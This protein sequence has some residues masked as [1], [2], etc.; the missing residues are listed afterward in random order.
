MNG[1]ATCFV[2]TAATTAYDTSEAARE[3]AEQLRGHAPRLVLFFAGST[4][5]LGALAAE[6]APRLPGVRVAGCSTM[7]EIGPLGLTQGGVSALGIGAPARVSATLVDLELLHFGDGLATV[8]RLAAELGLSPS[9]L[10]PDEHVFVT[11]TDGLSGLE[12]LLIASL[13]THAPRI[14]LVGGSAG[15][16]FR[17]ERTWVALDG[18][19]RSRAALVLLLEP[20][21]PFR[22]FHLHHFWPSE[23]RVVVTSAEPGRRLV[24]ELDGKPAVAVLSSLLGI[25]EDELRGDPSAIARQHTVFA[26]GVADRFYIRSVMTVTDDALLMGGAVGEGAVLRVM[27]GGDL[28]GATRDGV[29]RAVADIPS[30]G[31]GLLLF[32]C[33][34]RLLEA[35]AAGAERALYEAMT[36]IP[37]AG[38]TTYG[39]QFGPMQVNSTLTGLVLGSP[40]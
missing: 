14:P 31:S 26:F 40:T 20:G 36:P 13:G 15:D 21:V 18:S 19:A 10:R 8:D 16:D 28:V 4:H 3:L 30:E 27:H 7:G 11:L 35:A 38:F 2:G 17:F 22:P 32:N 12:E 39:E 37:A 5:D 9:A 6:L 33:G 29:A 24:H 23:R 1:A 25:D 34:G